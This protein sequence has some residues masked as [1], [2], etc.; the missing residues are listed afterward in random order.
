MTT[1]ATKATAES[2]AAHC[3]SGTE[4]AALESLYHPDAVSVEP[5]PM[6]GSSSAET[7]GLP[8]ILGKHAWWEGA[9]LEHERRVDGPWFHGPD[10]FALA[11]HLD[12]TERHSGLRRVMH[13]V[14]IYTVDDAGRIIREEFF[15]T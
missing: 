1:K 14:G 9:M 5:R 4:A 12:F 8:G 11:F 2:L 13:E 7:R 3:R 15:G 6:P 10:R